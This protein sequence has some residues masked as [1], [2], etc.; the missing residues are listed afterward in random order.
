MI[1]FTVVT[2]DASE[3][4]RQRIEA[5]KGLYRKAFPYDLLYPD[6]IAALI[7][8]RASL[9][10]DVLLLVGEDGRGQTLGFTLLFFFA[11]LQVAY[12][13]Y[14]ASDPARRTRGI[15]SA[16]YEATREL[17]LRKGARGM[18]L[19]VPPDERERL[20]EPE[21]LAVN[22]R[23]L[24]F[25]ERFDA[26]PIVGTLYEALDTESNQ[27]YPTFL[28]FDPLGRR[29]A[30]RR[31]QLRKVIRRILRAKYGLRRDD[32]EVVRIVHSVR[33]DPVTIRRPRYAA[34]DETSVDL[35]FLKPIHLV[36]GRHYELHHL[37]E[38]GYVERP[39]RID[40][41]LRGLADFPLE[42]VKP[43][44][45]GDAPIRAVHDPALVTYLAT[46][47]A[48]L[49]PGHLV[50][51]EVFPI[52]RPDRQPKELEI[53]A[54]Y[55]CLDTFTPLSNTAY[56]AARAAVDCAITAA[57]V[58]A[59]GARVAYALC[60]PPGHHA[61]IRA[62]GGFCYFNNAAIA[63]NRLSRGGK[64]VALLDVDHHHGNGSQ[65]IFYRRSD[66]FT[67]SI[68]GHPNLHYPHFSGFADER[69]AGDGVGF[70]RNYPLKDGIGD[71]AYIEVLDDALKQ[72]GRFRPDYLV[73]S[74]GFDI[75]RGDPTGG[76]VVTT[77]GIR[78]IGNRI[79]RLGLP[80]LIVQ[81]G[82]YSRHNLRVGARAFFLGLSA[83]LY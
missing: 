73:L 71:D 26:R 53:R 12:L 47:C 43:R 4:A 57:D 24:A 67:V 58:I 22:R 45:F 80:T 36:V 6:K 39:A 81:E 42:R 27:G 10:F 54:G 2:D 55:Y 19:D 51:P 49:K 60:R 32:P 77:R 62:F 37:R 76:F 46:V 9:D 50:Y 65:E 74:L 16:L 66:V 38:R 83:T 3:R 82:G 29:F 79:G 15:G 7:A 28:V 63:A 61:E 40:S 30:L 34:P 56:L 78:T 8:E 31:L 23:R 75:M 20:K 35:D 33:D 64:R 17:A 5:V 44:H 14:I 13:D 48:R 59:D 69:G 21:R 72:I 1:R 25:Y 68:H 18:F 41:I 70:N 11:D 52:R